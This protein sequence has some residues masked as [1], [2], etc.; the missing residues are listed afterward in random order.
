MNNKETKLIRELKYSLNP[1]LLL[2]DVT[3]QAMCSVQFVPSYGARFKY[4][5][6]IESPEYW[7]E[8]S[9]FKHTRAI[10][11]LDNRLNA[12]TRR[13]NDTE[14]ALAHSNRTY[15]EL[16]QKIPEEYHEK[17]AGIQAAWQSIVELSKHKKKLEDELKKT[18]QQ[19]NKMLEQDLI[20]LPHEELIPGEKGAV[21]GTIVLSFFDKALARNSK[22]HIIS[23]DG[24]KQKEFG[25][26]WLKRVDDARIDISNKI[27]TGEVHEELPEEF[28][29]PRLFKSPPKVKPGPDHANSVEEL[30]GIV[31]QEIPDYKKYLEATSQQAQLFK[32]A[33]I[34]A[35]EKGHS[36][37][38]FLD[39]WKW[40]RDSNKM[41]MWAEKKF[42][43]S[44]ADELGY[45]PLGLNP[46]K[47]IYTIMA[48]AFNPSD[49]DVVREQQ[50][51]SKTRG[52][53]SKAEK[54][55][56]KGGRGRKQSEYVKGFD[57]QLTVY[58][59]IDYVF[60]ENGNPTSPEEASAD[61]IGAFHK[62]LMRVIADGPTWLD[63][64]GDS[65]DDRFGKWVIFGKME[66]IESTPSHAALK[67]WKDHQKIDVADKAK[68]EQDEDY[69][70]MLTLFD[71]RQKDAATQMAKSIWDSKMASI[72][73]I[74]TNADRDGAIEI[75]NPRLTEISSLGTIILN[76]LGEW[77]S[78]LR[79]LDID[80]MNK[81]QAEAILRKGGLLDQIKN[82]IESNPMTIPGI[83]KY[84]KNLHES[85]QY[86]IMRENYESYQAE[87]G[88]ADLTI[89]R[90]IRDHDNIDLNDL[91][92]M[93][94]D[95]LK[96]NISNS[97]RRMEKYGFI[98]NDNGLYTTSSDIIDDAQAREWKNT[99]G[100][101]ADL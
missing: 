46:Y 96:T 86:N 88:P 76:Y 4:E 58:L 43:V 66:D 95:N 32:T 89:W 72:S 18:R 101:N 87:A 62:A 73:N 65:M 59:D 2:E 34:R 81:M 98:L 78:V 10:D 79:N 70:Q 42:G 27:E 54:A 75:I 37:S 15:D 7:E 55:K 56:T 84:I 12:L 45:E 29:D 39:K 83:A 23:I 38:Q 41:N 97:L 31:R 33:I 8:L 82:K 90:I 68:E 44:V 64:S 69:R 80:N 17:H 35:V 19:M 53:R 25:W 24:E 74:L 14:T 5:H 48:R 60:D 30:V 28:R 40:T 1:S 26:T 93:V 91:T 77:K 63:V 67:W 71:A 99:R 92:R 21:G 61:Q 85:Y 6:D 50:T 13:I 20:E 36:V 22:D 100:I 47:T 51:G 94:P 52:K 11:G 9:P 57:V 3:T 49:R 16:E